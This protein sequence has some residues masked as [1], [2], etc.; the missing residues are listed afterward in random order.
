MKRLHERGIAVD[1]VI[2]II[3]LLVSYTHRVGL[4]PMNL[5]HQYHPVIMEKASAIGA[6]AHWLNM[7]KSI[8]LD[9]RKILPSFVPTRTIGTPG[10]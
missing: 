10:A 6:R 8:T 9:E 1:T 3:Y 2:S 7:V 5:T 4:E